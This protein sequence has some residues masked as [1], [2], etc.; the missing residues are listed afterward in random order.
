MQWHFNDSSF[1][2]W[3]IA[4]WKS[5]VH[6][7]EK[8]HAEDNDYADF[9]FERNLIKLSFWQIYRLADVRSFFILLLLRLVDVTQWSF[10]W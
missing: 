4:A 6:T 3:V 5:D 2:N 8:E 1:E 10:S 9:L 7:V